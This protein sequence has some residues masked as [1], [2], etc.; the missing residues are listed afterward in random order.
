M[1]RPALSFPAL[2]QI[3]HMFRVHPL[4]PRQNGIGQPQ[5]MGNH[6]EY[7][8][9]A[10]ANHSKSQSTTH[11]TVVSVSTP[12][13]TTYCRHYLPRMHEQFQY[14]LFVLQTR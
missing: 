3:M 6:N 14:A 10:V 1:V 8:F 11:Y 2:V 9:R 12:L 13:L 7:A 4:E 5:L